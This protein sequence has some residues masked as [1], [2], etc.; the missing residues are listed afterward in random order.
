[1]QSFAALI[2]AVVVVVAV[3]ALAW[4]L[5]GMFGVELIGWR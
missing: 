1:M 4:S 3:V 5:H 2:V